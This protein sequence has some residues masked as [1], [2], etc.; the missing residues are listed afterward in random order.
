MGYPI[1]PSGSF[2]NDLPT[3]SW[4]QPTVWWGIEVG[5]LARVLPLGGPDWSGELV[6]ILS[7]GVRGGKDLGPRYQVMGRKG[8]IVL[9][10]YALSVERYQKKDL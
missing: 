2:S 4:A 8:T 10:Y 6:L 5:S 7:E 3:P 1:I 9:P